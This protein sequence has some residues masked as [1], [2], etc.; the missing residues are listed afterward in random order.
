MYII[1]YRECACSGWPG[2]NE[3]CTRVFNI[4]TNMVAGK[5]PKDQFKLVW[6]RKTTFKREFDVRF[7]FRKNIIF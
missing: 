1:W 3:T 6:V 5:V 7:K 2:N 4:C